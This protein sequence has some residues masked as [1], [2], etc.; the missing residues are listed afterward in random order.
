MLFFFRKDRFSRTA[1][2]VA[3]ALMLSSTSRSLAEGSSSEVVVLFDAGQPRRFEI[4]RDELSFKDVSGAASVRLK[5]AERSVERLRARA[6]SLMAATGMELKLVIYPVGRPRN[7]S[8][9]RL[10][11]RRVLVRLMPDADAV[12]VLGRVPGVAYWQ[13]VDYLPGAVL[14][15]AAEP[16]GALELAE[17]L[18]VLP[19]VRSAEAQLA[20]RHQPKLV[21]N[22]TLF[23]YQW[24][25]RN[26]GQWS[27][28]AG[29]DLH[30][31]NV[32]DN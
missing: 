9:R 21:P 2:A 32:W 6:A 29:I 14:V 23:N 27:G 31:T 22:D 20:R 4:A 11:T 7:E 1:W 10:L 3:A 13:T 16:T 15:E 28:T 25:L 17:S 8:T 12:S 5:P 18:R 19:G 26:T 24:Y 30:V